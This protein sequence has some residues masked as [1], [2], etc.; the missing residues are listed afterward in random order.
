MRGDDQF[1]LARMRRGGGDQRALA[2]G[3]LQRGEIGLVGRRR[4]HVELEVAADEHVAGAELRQAL[5]VG[6]RAR[7]A[8]VEAFEQ[9]ADRAGQF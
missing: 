2:D 1:V 5:G 8:Q 4:W 7:Q 9:M 3:R 6:R